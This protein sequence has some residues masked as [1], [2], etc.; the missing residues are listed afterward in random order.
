MNI[1]VQEY[2]YLYL[3]IAIL[4]IWLLLSSLRSDLR[5]MLMQTGLWVAAAGPVA[6]YWHFQDYWH[7]PLIWNIG[8][9][10]PETLL[11]G[12]G[13][14]GICAGLYPVLH[15]ATIRK[16]RFPSRWKEF[17]M[18]ILA[19]V[20]A[21]IVFSGSLRVNSIIVVSAVFLACAAFIVWRRRDLFLPSL[22]TGIES[23]ALIVPIYWMFLYLAPEFLS[24][25]WVLWNMPMGVT[26]LFG[27][28]FT[29]IIWFFC[30]GCFMGVIYH[31]VTGTELSLRK[32]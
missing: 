8:P 1:M 29:E 27:I 16:A 19:F 26:I 14:G 9:V 11:F 28:P 20:L 17:S 22:L 32:S 31:F 5:R 23:A 12:F 15:G 30:W 18:M 7:P 6:E 25:Y 24:N 3:G 21:L 10:A 4:V 13:I 2:T